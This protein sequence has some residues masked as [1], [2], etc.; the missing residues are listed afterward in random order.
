[1]H[2][3]C[4]PSHSLAARLA[5]QCLECEEQGQCDQFH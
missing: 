4:T 1:M 5:W 3:I 2:F